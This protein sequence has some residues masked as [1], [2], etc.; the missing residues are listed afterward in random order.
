[1]TPLVTYRD[2]PD[3][4]IQHKHFENKDKYYDVDKTPENI[5]EHN[6]S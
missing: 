2:Y 1:M 6:R 4:F 5:K 3:I